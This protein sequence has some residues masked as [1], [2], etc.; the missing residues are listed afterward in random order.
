MD[1]KSLEYGGD[2][3]IPNC[4]SI[5]VYTNRAKS[6]KFVI[7][8]KHFIA[9]AATSTLMP[10]KRLACLRFE[11]MSFMCKTPS[12]VGILTLYTFYAPTMPNT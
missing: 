9:F 12:S 4:V 8:V 1:R 6:V 7:W 10:G 2:P 3:S 11:I 5:V